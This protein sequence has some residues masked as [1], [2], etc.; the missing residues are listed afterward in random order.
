MRRAASVVA[1]MAVLLA[2]R[3][4]PSDVTNRGSNTG[5]C[6]P[7][8]CGDLPAGGCGFSMEDGC[9]SR[10]RCECG[11]GE[12]C[13]EESQSPGTCQPCIPKT[14]EDVRAAGGCGLQQ[15][16]CGGWLR[17]DGL[18][19]PGEGCLEGFL[20]PGTCQPC[21]PLF[22]S[23]AEIG[24]ACGMAV[25]G[26]GEW[27]DC[28]G[29]EHPCGAGQ[30]MAALRPA[31]TR[32][33]GSTAADVG[34]AD[35]LPDGTIVLAWYASAES[36]LRLDR[37]TATGSE[38]LAAF[39]VTGGDVHPGLTAGAGGTLFLRLD[40]GSSWSGWATGSVDLGA[41]PR[42]APYLVELGPDGRLVRELC[43]SSGPCDGAVLAARADGTLLRVDGR[44]SWVERG[45]DASLLLASWDGARGAL[46][47]GSCNVAALHPDGDVVC[48]G[49]VVGPFRD[50]FT[51]AV[52]RVPAVTKVSVDGS[53][54]WRVKLDGISGGIAGIGVDPG[55]GAVV[56]VG[57]FA[58]FATFAGD[59]LWWR[60]IGPIEPAGFAIGI[61]ADATPLFARQLPSTASGP[62]A[63]AEGRFAAVLGE[64]AGW[65]VGYETRGGAA[66]NATWHGDT[67]SYSSTMTRLSWRGAELVA[68]VYAKDPLEGDPQRAG[69]FHVVGFVPAPGSPAPGVTP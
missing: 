9:G 14:C 40:P 46:P 16:G 30:P 63:V 52:A 67:G 23:C 29:A 50:G 59:V 32:A 28:G 60:M 62:I 4:H 68:S 19:G 21:E 41:G 44:G 36:V 38:P 34:S 47:P 24:K 15:D 25:N 7:R 43:P 5:P 53:V 65:V 39:D 61:G 35:V 37:L 55:S 6:V 66:W 57:A 42:T 1:S 31:W 10:I 11:P 22:A 64:F 3:S 20:V 18:C 12:K 58:G 49:T 33:I 17:C 51:S 8:T 27:L 2:C 45:D 69:P 26:C 54:R 56:A 13:V 48:G